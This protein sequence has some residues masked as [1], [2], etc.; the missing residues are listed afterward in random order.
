MHSRGR[1]SWDIEVGHYMRHRSG[2]VSVGPGSN[3][4]CRGPWGQRNLTWAEIETGFHLTYDLFKNHVIYKV[5]TI[6]FDDDPSSHGMRKRRSNGYSSLYWGDWSVLNG[7]R[8]PWTLA[9]GTHWRSL[10]LRSGS[11]WRGWRGRIL[12]FVLNERGLLWKWG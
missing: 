12:T 9:S 11:C 3:R 10:G 8:I 6:I 7:I 4:G 1:C 2:I 5:E